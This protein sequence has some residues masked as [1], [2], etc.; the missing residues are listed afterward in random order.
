[1]SMTVLPAGL[2]AVWCSVSKC[3]LCRQHFMPGGT[4]PFASH[5]CPARPPSS[6]AAWQPL[7]AAH[8]A[9]HSSTVATRF[10]ADR[11]GR[12]SQQQSLEL[13]IVTVAA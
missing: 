11:S 13:W 8:D 2:V 3:A 12:F 6:T 5:C 10:F 1:M 7:A 9:T 4:R